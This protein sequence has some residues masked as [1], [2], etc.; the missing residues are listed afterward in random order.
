MQ[1]H[2]SFFIISHHIAGSLRIIPTE[3]L[4]IHGW[5]LYDVALQEVDDCHAIVGGDE[6]TFGHEVLVVG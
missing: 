4:A 6:N 3:N 1:L 2:P 5:F